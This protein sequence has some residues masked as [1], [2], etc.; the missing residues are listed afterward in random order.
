MKGVLQCHP[1]EGPQL[2]PAPR[3]LRQWTLASLRLATAPLERPAAPGQHHAQQ[4]LV[5]AAAGSALQR[6][7]PVPPRTLARAAS[8]G[9]TAQVPRNG[10]ASIEQAG[11]QQQSVSL[12]GPVSLLHC[13]RM[14]KSARHDQRHHYWRWYGLAA[15]WQDAAAQHAGRCWGSG[16]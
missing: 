12:R 13:T 2:K 11:L 10:A 4:T 8:S 6:V 5:G 14:A 1:Q 15:G 9:T 7:P 3:Q 16:H